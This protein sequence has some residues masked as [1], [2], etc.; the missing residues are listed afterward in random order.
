MKQKKVMSLVLSLIMIFTSCNLCFA[1]ENIIY[2]NESDNDVLNDMTEVS[3]ESGN[4]SSQAVY[5][6]ESGN[7][8]EAEETEETTDDVTETTTET[9]VIEEDKPYAVE[10]G[11]IY[12]GLKEFETIDENNH[13]ISVKRWEITKS[14]KS[15]VSADIPAVIEGVNIEAIG[16]GAFFENT[17]LKS[18]KISEGITDICASAFSGC[19]NLSSLEL[20]KGLKNI[21]VWAF[22]RCKSLESV[23]IPASVE[24]ILTGAFGG[25]IKLKSLNVESENKEYMS[26]DGIVF[27]KDKTSLVIY[28]AGLYATEYKIPEGI[29]STYAQAFNGTAYLK[30]VILPDSMKV[31]TNQPLTGCESVTSV[32]IPKTAT[33]LDTFAFARCGLTELDIPDSVERIGTLAF[34]DSLNLKSV[35]LPKNL[36]SL[37]TSA[38]E[39]CKSLMEIKIPESLKYIP[40]RTFIWCDNLK[41]I[42]IPKSVETIGE[43]AFLGCKDLTIYCYRDSY[44]ETYAK[45]N[46]FKN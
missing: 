22:Y 6:Y 9:A 8:E 41:A 45:E 15:V 42:E 34:H 25:C 37:G 24:F 19:E 20:P 35:K 36:K 23:D 16:A 27:N 14:D 17:E 11:N 1:E 31:I 29:V 13:I 3:I 4:V 21:D 39:K 33:E 30:K 2:E 10:G 44:A 46:N 12:Y 43:N 28:P 40:A 26:V 5:L 7:S 38:F 32:E 18:V